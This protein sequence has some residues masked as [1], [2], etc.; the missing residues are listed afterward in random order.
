[1]TINMKKSKVIK[2]ESIKINYFFGVNTILWTK[3]R[4]E[5]LADFLYVY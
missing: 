4:Y 2:K 1:M 5:N 3:I